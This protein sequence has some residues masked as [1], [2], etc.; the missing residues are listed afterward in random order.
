MWQKTVRTKISTVS[1]I[2]YINNLNINMTVLD[3][4]S[5]FMLKFQIPIFSTLRN[6]Q[7][8]I[9]MAGA[10]KLITNMK[11]HFLFVLNSIC[12][13][14]V[15]I[16]ISCCWKSRI[17]LWKEALDSKL[18]LLCSVSLTKKSSACQSHDHFVGMAGWVCELTRLWYTLNFTFL[19][20]FRPDSLVTLA[21]RA[22][23]L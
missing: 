23:F 15:V 22:R 21:F 4:V 2:F 19:H 8:S 10:F 9:V 6:K 3:S 1:K 7:T 20:S 5:I 18:A 16:E 11:R 12:L 14:S 17:W 13:D